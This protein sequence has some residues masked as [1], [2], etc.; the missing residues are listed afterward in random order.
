[1]V[2]TTEKV[3]EEFHPRLKQFILKR[4]PDEQ[5]AED[6][7]Q[8]VFLKIHA[9]IGTL[10]DEEKLQSWMYQITRNVIA[11][12]YREHKATVALT[13][14]LLL[15]EEPVVDDDVV[16]DLLPGVRAMVHSLPAEYREALLLTEY[17]GLTQRELAERM[18][19]SLSGAKSRVQRAREKLKAML[20]DC[21]HF[22]FDRLGKIID[23]Q[24]N[25]AC[26][27]NQGCASGCR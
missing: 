3:W 2:M 21:C 9:R 16:K 5:N 14:A 11:D 8:E 23:Y 17:A 20:L 10:R 1:M 6:I 25:C 15:P 7:L 24:P 19:L 26:C 13:E 4:I 18:G 27:T 12:Y 22:E